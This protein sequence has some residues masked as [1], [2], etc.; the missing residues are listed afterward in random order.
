MYHGNLAAWAACV[1]CRKASYLQAIRHTLYSLAHERWMTRLVIRAN[2]LASWSA[3]RVVY[4]AEAAVSHHE[5]IGF[6]RRNAVVIPNG[7][8]LALLRPDPIARKETRIHLGIADSTPVVGI[9]GRSHPMKD[10]H[11]FLE[12]ARGL[13][14]H[15]TRPHFLLVGP[16]LTPQNPVI[17]S[18][19]GLPTLAGRIHA[20]GEQNDATRWINA[21]DVFALSSWSDAFPN[22]VG[23]AMA[24]GVPCAVTDVGDVARL[25][26]DT[27][28][29]VP[30]RDPRRLAEGIDELLSM[31]V[32]ERRMLGVR[33]RQRIE[34]CF[35]LDVIVERYQEL[36]REVLASGVGGAPTRRT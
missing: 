31:P 35:S 25:V 27:A 4:V 12:A 3:V 24:C 32:A 15:P 2:A 21:M 20:V 8:D 1:F 19:F 29:I 28:C 16:G 10:H 17:A 23:E 36:Y 7:F 9:I 18:Y 30:P 11:T 5:R 26:G 22:V 33:A 14:G 13:S 34:H 6:S